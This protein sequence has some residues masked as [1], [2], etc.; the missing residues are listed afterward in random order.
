MHVLIVGSRGQLGQALEQL[1]DTKARAKNNVKVT[2][3]QRPEYD[4]ANSQIADQVAALRPDVVINAAAWT[5]VDAAEA[6]PAATFAANA[7]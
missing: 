4:I 3:W 1:Y 6:S 5:N 2:S 7:E